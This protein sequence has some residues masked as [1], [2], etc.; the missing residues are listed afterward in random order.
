MDK[1][2]VVKIQEWKQDFDVRNFLEFW[3]LNNKNT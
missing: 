1:S 2:Y 3:N